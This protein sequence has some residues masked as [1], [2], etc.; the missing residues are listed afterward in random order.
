M[1]IGYDFKIKHLKFIFSVNHLKE[2]LSLILVALILSACDA[3]ETW[4]LGS[5][6][7][8]YSNP[9][10]I[11]NESKY[12]VTIQGTSSEEICPDSDTDCMSSKYGKWIETGYIVKENDAITM[13]VDGIIH[14]AQGF[15][16]TEND[17][18]GQKWV[19]PA[20][21]GNPTEITG[22]NFSPQQQITV[23]T[24]DCTTGS[25]SYGTSEPTKWTW[26]SGWKYSIVYC[27]AN[28]T[29][30]EGGFEC[31]ASGWYDGD[32]KEGCAE[33]P[34]IGDACYAKICDECWAGLCM[35]T[36]SWDCQHEARNASPDE[37]EYSYKHTDR[38]VCPSTDEN[39]IG[40]PT[41]YICDTNREYDED[42]CYT[43]TT[44]AYEPEDSD[45]CDGK[46]HDCGVTESDTKPNLDCT[47]SKRVTGLTYDNGGVAP[48]NTCG[49]THTCWN[50]GG[51]Q[52][53]AIQAGGQCPTYCDSDNADASEEE[54]CPSGCTH[55]NG[56]Y[57]TYDETNGD[58]ANPAGGKSFA[59][60]GGTL[61]LQIINPNS[62]TELEDI[63]DLE[64]DIEYNNQQI[65]S[66]ESENTQLYATLN[67]QHN[68][69]N[70]YRDDIQELEQRT[71]SLIAGLG[72]EDQSVI[73]QLNDIKI[74]YTSPPVTK[75]AAD[76]TESTTNDPDL[77]ESFDTF[78]SQINL[79]GQ[80][81]NEE[82]T[83]DKNT[84]WKDTA[85]TMEVQT[86][87]L[88]TSTSVLDT[89]VNPSGE[90]TPTELQ[91][92]KADAHTILTS[93]NTAIDDAQATQEQIEANNTAIA[94]YESDNDDLNQQ[95]LETNV[96]DNDDLKGGYTVYVKGG[97]IIGDSGQFLHAILC[98]DIDPNV[99]DES[100]C[101]ELFNNGTTSMFYTTDINTKG[102]AGYIWFKIE[103][104][105]QDY[106]NNSLS[107]DILIGKTVYTSGFNS[108]ISGIINDIKNNVTS[109][110]KR[111]YKG[112]TC[113]DGG[114]MTSSCT[115][116]LTSMAALLYLYIIVFGMMYLFGLI[117]TDHVDFVMRMFKVAVVIVL[118][119]P[120]SFDFF[121]DYL[122]N[123]FW[124]FSDTLLSNATG[125]PIGNPFEF[126]AY[127]FNV[128]IL[129]E[130][131]YFK[132]VGIMVQGLMGVVAFFLLIYGCVTFIEAFFQAF[133]VYMMCF[134]GLGICFALA[135]FYLSFFLFQHTRHLFEAWF[136][137]MV[138]LSVQPTILMIGIIII[139]SMLQ[140][141]LERLFNYQVCFKCA[142][143]FTF[144]LPGFDQVGTT[145]LFCVYW[146]AE[147]GA[148]NVASVLSKQL[149]IIPSAI[150]FSIMVNIMKIYA[151]KLANDV[152]GAIVGSS[153]M[154]KG[155]DRPRSMGTNPLEGFKAHNMALA[156]KLGLTK[157]DPNDP[158]VEKESFKKLRNKIL[159]GAFTAGM[160]VD[161][162]IVGAAIAKTLY[163]DQLKK[164]QDKFNKFWSSPK[165]NEED[166]NKPMP[167]D[168]NSPN[169]PNDPNS[170]NAPGAPTPNTANGNNNFPDKESPNQTIATKDSIDQA[171]AIR[172]E[173]QDQALAVKSENQERSLVVSGSDDRSGNAYAETSRLSVENAPHESPID[174]QAR[175]SS[176]QKQQSDSKPRVKPGSMS[177][178]DD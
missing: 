62:S 119:Q 121:N 82:G 117:K 130:N 116:Y 141:I 134:V 35:G 55:L 73:N 17:G 69:I 75:T 6:S 2:I 157:S 128:I 124:G 111:I 41:A 85:I 76:G 27:Y 163:K 172:S 92:Y 50:T 168:P 58:P 89:N 15:E 40:N 18:L 169:S 139:N 57:K 91:V 123:A 109:A 12:S 67:E 32:I 86:E 156:R 162:P 114:E 38:D 96:Y 21:R 174:Q 11:K 100:D 71:Q 129:D 99:N 140:A 52:L 154:F 90:T 34:P 118:I 106:T 31:G 63:D 132:I 93:L 126:I 51:Y 79:T 113:S 104:N 165:S 56:S 152:S 125:A 47:E 115:S 66:L 84:A 13:S 88:T 23:T 60:V 98:E 178:I 150:N 166:K 36:C 59:A 120:G 112:V 72:E 1:I 148:D 137:A 171:L 3:S 143:P 81:S 147:W 107:Y 159:K 80:Y 103:D 28:G 133:L 74:Q 70:N 175:D 95:I 160:G 65:S 10:S 110:A 101:T 87:D 77:L 151:D 25:S 8:S 64:E 108:V 61:Y 19:I 24:E 161:N 5:S 68:K 29:N 7:D 105:D 26:E 4:C 138:K 44:P 78:E 170:P 177:D 153:N 20:N 54:K 22:T 45:Y 149:N 33:S 49:S 164:Y 97:P 136:K 39:Q 83:L 30:W 37:S 176:E 144:A 146:F 48:F 142:I 46:E 145:T 42:D 155:A 167:N 14:L 43:A 16:E 127:S 131:T 94:E 122:F 158:N 135:P 173:S 102:K 53:F 9:D